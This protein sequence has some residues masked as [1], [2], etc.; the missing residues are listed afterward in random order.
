[1]NVHLALGN[2]SYKCC[3]QSSLSSIFYF[4]W[5]LVVNFLTKLTPHR[6]KLTGVLTSTIFYKSESTCNWFSKEISG[7]YFYFFYL[8]V[9]FVRYNQ[10]GSNLHLNPVQFE[11]FDFFFFPEL[12]CKLWWESLLGKKSKSGIQILGGT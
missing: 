3:I 1:M 12:Y 4:P 5:K 11:N 2:K 10:I 7:F 8:Y 9:I 6:I